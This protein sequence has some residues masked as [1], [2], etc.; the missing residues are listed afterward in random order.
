[1]NKKEIA[2]IVIMTILFSLFAL[3]GS[4]KTTLFFLEKNSAQQETFNFLEDNSELTLPYTENEKEHLVDVKNVMR[5]VDWFF[6]G[7]TFILFIFL[8]YNYFQKK[9]KLKDA[10]C[11]SWVSL[12]SILLFGICIL[13][14]FP[15]LF[16]FF[17]EIFFPQGNW[18]FPSDSLLI[19]TFSIDFF[20]GIALK[21]FFLSLLFTSIFIAILLYIR[22][23]GKIKAS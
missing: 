20:I 10:L 19:Q 16:T 2:L 8:F 9:I 7:L 5:K 4:Y 14:F 1:M 17:H 6:L 23:H 3:L 21:I 12:V 22:K 11:A 13:F 18:I 15:L